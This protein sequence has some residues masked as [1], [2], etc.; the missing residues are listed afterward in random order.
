MLDALARIGAQTI[1]E[2]HRL[3]RIRLYRNQG[4]GQQT[5]KEIRDLAERVAQHFAARDDQASPGA[6]EESEPH[7]APADWMLSVDVMARLVVSHRLDA[8]EQR[9][10]RTFLGLESLP[11]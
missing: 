3:P 2:L 4:I 6:L 1:G 5:V 7:A 10:L 11:R 8:T 9:L